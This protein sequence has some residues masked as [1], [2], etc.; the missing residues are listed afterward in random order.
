MKLAYHSVGTSREPRASI[1]RSLPVSAEYSGF[2]LSLL[3]VSVGSGPGLPTVTNAAAATR[4]AAG[5]A[6]AAA[7]AAA[8]PSGARVRAG[9]ARQ[10]RP[11]WKYMLRGA[12]GLSLGA[13]IGLTWLG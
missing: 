5:A 10:R 7:A 3:E 1:S 13:A 4:G 2:W 6:A 9:A 8:A 11:T 12:R